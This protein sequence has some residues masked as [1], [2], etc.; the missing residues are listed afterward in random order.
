[1]LMKLP[2]VFH[3]NFNKTVEFVCNDHLYRPLLIAR[4]FLEFNKKLI[5][6][7]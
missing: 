1:M 4:R 5:P 7:I 2:P 3:R 6:I